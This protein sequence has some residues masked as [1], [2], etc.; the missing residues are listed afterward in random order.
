MQG[1][2]GGMESRREKEVKEV[3]NEALKA[4]GV[5]LILATTGSVIAEDSGPALPTTSA[6]SGTIP[7]LAQTPQSIPIS[8]PVPIPIPGGGP[9]GTTANGGGGSGTS[10]GNE[11]CSSC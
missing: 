6:S 2:G 3:R 7:V 8:I 5:F 10:T 1:C 4:V 9:F 11:P